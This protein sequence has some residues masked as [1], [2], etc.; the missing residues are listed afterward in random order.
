M[1]SWISPFVLTM[2][3][4]GAAPAGPRQAVRARRAAGSFAGANLGRG[5]GFRLCRVGARRPAS[6]GQDVF[7]CTP[8]RRE[9]VTPCAHCAKP[10]PDAIGRRTLASVLRNI[11]GQQRFPAGPAWW[12]RSDFGIKKGCCAR[13]RRGLFDG[14]ARAPDTPCPAAPEEHTACGWRGQRNAPA[15]Q[16][17]RHEH[18]GFAQCGRR[19]VFDAAARRRARGCRTSGSNASI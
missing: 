16:S 3:G 18:R 8:M 19:A 14:P 6:A 1:R 13:R 15:W 5:F 12:G 2:A 11:D 4:A 10:L 7:V 17:T 9:R